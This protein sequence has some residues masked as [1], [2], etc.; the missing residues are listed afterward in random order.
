[1]VDLAFNQALV[2]LIAD[3]HEQH[4]SSTSSLSLVS[5]PVQ[6]AKV[7]LNTETYELQCELLVP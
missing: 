2:N 3:E 7:E 6:R 1:M 5:L 4:S